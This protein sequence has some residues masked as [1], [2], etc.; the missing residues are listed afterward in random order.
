MN[1]EIPTPRVFVPLLQP[2]RY[3]GAH[4][5]RGSGKSHFFAEMLIE[6]CLM[7]P[8]RAVCLREIQKS[9]KQSIKLL[10][11]DKI[12]S[13]GVGS[14][15]DSLETEI[16]GKNGSLIIFQGLQNH[17]A[18]SI[19]SLEG[20]DIA[21]LVEAQAISQRSLDLLRPTIRKDGSEIWAEWNPETADVPI[22][23]LLRGPNKVAGS[24][25]VEANWRDNPFFPEVL[26]VEMEGDKLRDYDKYLHIWEGHY[27]RTLE[28]SIYANEIR[29]AF[30]EKR[31]TRVLPIPGKPIETFWDL[32]KRDHTAI[33]FA[34]MQMGEYRIL[35]YYQNRGMRLEHYVDRVK[36]SGYQISKVWLPHD[37]RQ[38]RINADSVEQSIRALM[39]NI[40]VQVIPRM[41]NKGHGIEAV[42]RIFGQCY[43]DE[44]GTKEGMTALARFRYDVDQTTGGY[45]AQP[46]HDE[47]SDGADAFAQL[48]LSLK[49][50][51][52]SVLRMAAPAMSGLRAF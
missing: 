4:G 44:E 1:L 31:V 39:P 8:T 28:G 47:Y 5:G 52:S 17:T 41:T 40:S 42:R 30:E 26:K 10:L 23:L 25:V 48:A 2:A 11:D 12:K 19:K 22:D 21:L 16:R 32:G 7:R 45:S 24:V 3:K 20:F 51:D 9:I 29:A 18:D 34:Q 46:L 49:E 38:E 33:W 27:R 15:F 37:A 13:L 14:Q 50:P 35:R 36:N 43:F 6:T